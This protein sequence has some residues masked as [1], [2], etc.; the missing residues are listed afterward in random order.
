MMLVV[1]WEEGK[2]EERGLPVDVK[3]SEVLCEAFYGRLASLLHVAMF[4]SDA[5]Y[6]KKI[7]GT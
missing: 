5:P 1:V 7:V 3:A 6:V 4:N 2:G